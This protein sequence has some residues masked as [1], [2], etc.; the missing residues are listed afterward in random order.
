MVA[1][2]LKLY[3]GLAA[4]T[5]LPSF[6]LGHLHQPI[7][8]FVPGA[9]SPGMEFAIAQHTHFSVTPSATS[10]LPAICHIHAYL[11][12]F[13]PFP[14]AFIR[15]VESIASGVFLIF[16]VPQSLELVIKKSL[17]VLERDVFRGAASRRHMLRVVR[18]EYEL[19]LEAG[20]AH[21]MVAT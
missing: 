19:T 2:F 13:D 8:F 16:L 4:I 11:G 1:A 5:P 3:Q 18:G 17:H 7:R 14:A 10:I 6:V 20:V 21:S 15:T 12:R 9:L